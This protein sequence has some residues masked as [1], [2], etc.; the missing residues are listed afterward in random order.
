MMDCLMKTRTL[1]VSGTFR[2]PDAGSL[3]EVSYIST[4][5][6]FFSSRK[7]ERCEGRCSLQPRSTGHFPPFLKRTLIDRASNTRI[8]PKW[9]LPLNIFNNAFTVSFIP[10]PYPPSRTSNRST[11]SLMTIKSRTIICVNYFTA[12]SLMWK[13]MCV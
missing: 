2:L 6:P 11:L 4:S 7:Q 1:Y 3:Y 12:T 5:P 13:W 8:S 9:N 10:L